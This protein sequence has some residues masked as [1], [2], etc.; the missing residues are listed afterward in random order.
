M[1]V[2]DRQY[3]RECEKETS[4]PRCNLHEYIGRLRAEN[5]L[6][7]AAAEGRT[8]TFTARTLHQDE[9]QHEERHQDVD[10]EKEID[11]ELHRD[12]EYR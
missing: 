5:I 12:R 9:E 10:R 11:Q 8:Q 6:G 7:H 4:Q 1:R 3:E 2:E